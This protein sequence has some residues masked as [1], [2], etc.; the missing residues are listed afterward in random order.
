MIN[1]VK[2]NKK[3]L[4]IVVLLLIIVNI[5]NVFAPYLLKL[6]IDKI[7]TNATL[8]TIVYILI[9]YTITRI[10][11]IVI[12]CIRNKI[13][14]IISTKMLNELRTETFDKVISMKAKDFLKFSSSD[15]Y[16]RLTV[17]AEN[18]KD[19]FSTNMP[20]I[21][22]DML[23]I[24]FMIIVMFIID[25]KLALLGL[26]IIIILGICSFVIVQRLKKIQE[27]T[28]NKR[29]LEY[30]EFSEDYNKSKLTRLFELQEK[31]I[32]KV[33]KIMNEE[34]KNRYKYTIT[35]S[36]LWPL[37]IFTEAIG[38]Y[39]ILYYVLNIDVTIS[40]GTVYIF[41]YYIR[42]C[43][44]PLKEF[45]NQLE[46]IQNA[47]VSLERINTILKIKEKE[48]IEKGL[49]VEDLKGD[50]EFKNVTFAYKRKNILDN[51]SFNIKHGEKTAIIGKTGIG[52][53]TITKILMK[54]YPIK[55]GSITID[56]YNIDEISIKSIR[57]NIT[58]VSQDVY[59]L[60]DTV[61][62]NI[63]LE[64]QDVT[65]EEILKIM[66]SIGAKPLLER[67]DNGLN[68][69][70]NVNRL[71]KGELQ[72]IA[73]IRAMVHGANIYIFDEPT[74]NIDLR[75]EKMIQSIIDKISK[76]STVIIIAHRLSTIQNVDRILELKSDKM[77][78]K[79]GLYSNS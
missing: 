36:F 64:K 37:S 74:S 14:N 25:T 28:L 68:E 10:A 20:I 24:M 40:L 32:K 46:E 8:K 16:T 53:T 54:L 70:I 9:A 59:V 41:L 29:D 23:Y 33:N 44:S 63:V 43:F 3:Y 76:T 65:D 42:Q 27:V 35:N 17:D 72:I 6:I 26:G 5:L 13:T 73:F 2:K 75:T 18:V 77:E 31:N 62:K 4:L 61:R 55:K 30:R 48:D 38:I 78:E 60:K 51:I 47:Q 69:V 12:E 15:I 52:K 57:K 19:L 56:G 49:E 71:S 45:F 39:V 11:I 22:N 67:L 50:I 1:I 66:E 34:L 58:Y 79:N 21:V 7:T